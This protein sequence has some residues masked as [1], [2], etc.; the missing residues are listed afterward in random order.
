MFIPVL[1]I[2]LFT[3]LNFPL[4]D[5]M[6]FSLRLMDF[7]DNACVQTSLLMDAENVYL[8]IILFFVVSCG[9]RIVMLRW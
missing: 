5:F 7:V 4:V 9:I 8:A 3:H 2:S 6:D 1:F